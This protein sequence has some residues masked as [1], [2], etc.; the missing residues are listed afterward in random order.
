MKFFYAAAI[1]TFSQILFAQDEKENEVEEGLP[2]KA[3]RSIDIKNNPQ[4]PIAYN[5]TEEEL[6]KLIKNR[7]N[8]Y[9]LAANKVNC[10]NLTKT[11]IVSK[12]IKIY[13]NKKN[14]N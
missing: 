10:N 1:I 3:T 13:E 9:C 6:N 4:R 2:L 11:Q 12:I 14:N 5:A 7:S 8:I